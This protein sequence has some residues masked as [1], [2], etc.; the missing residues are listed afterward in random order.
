MFE[1]YEQEECSCGNFVVLEGRSAECDECS[2]YV[3]CEPE[4]DDPG[5]NGTDDD[6]GEDD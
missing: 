3:C 4:H 2:D 5:D 1:E 6:E